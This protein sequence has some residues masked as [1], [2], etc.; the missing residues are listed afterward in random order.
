MLELLPSHRN[1]SDMKRYFK[2]GTEFIIHDGESNI[3]IFIG[4]EGEEKHVDST[5]DP[6]L[7]LELNAYIR[8][9]ACLE[10]FENMF[11]KYWSGR[12]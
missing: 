5:L 4:S 7:N 11:M 1:S 10:I 9:H 6:H 3:L 2:I 8:C 12:K